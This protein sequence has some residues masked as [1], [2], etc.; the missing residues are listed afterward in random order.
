MCKLLPLLIA[1]GVFL[2]SAEEIIALPQLTGSPENFTSITASWTDCFGAY[3]HANGT[4]YVS[5]YKDGKQ[6]V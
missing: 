4:E 6:H 1:L 5:G 2:G 3:T